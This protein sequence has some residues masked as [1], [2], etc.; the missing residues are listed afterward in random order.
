VAFKNRQYEIDVDEESFLV[1]CN[2][3]K[4]LWK[5]VKLLASGVLKDKLG[6][7]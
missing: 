4:K 6:V 2:H 7:H 1:L 3:V 5:P